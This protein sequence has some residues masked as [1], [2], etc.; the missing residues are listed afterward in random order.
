M[1]KRVFCLKPARTKKT[2][3]LA[4]PGCQHFNFFRPVSAA[5]EGNRTLVVSL[6]GFCSTSELHPHLATTLD[7]SNQ[8]TDQRKGIAHHHAPPLPESQTHHQAPGSKH[9]A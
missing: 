1:G 5:G 8:P 9:L 6:E 2:K 7:Q 4:T 3:N